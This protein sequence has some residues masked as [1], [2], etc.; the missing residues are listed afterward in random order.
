MTTHPNFAESETL[1][2]LRK[3]EEHESQKSISNELNWS[4]GKV[5]YII[6]AL[7]EKGLIKIENFSNQKDKR[8]YRYLLTKRGIEEKISLTERFI[9]RKKHEY[10]EL[11]AEL[12]RMKSK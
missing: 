5:N 6:K 12:N 4:I 2:I 1:A 8:G 11:V 10:D 7:I 9:E 3:V